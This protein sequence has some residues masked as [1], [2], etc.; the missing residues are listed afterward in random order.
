M[1]LKG[2]TEP[3]KCGSE[4]QS[5]LKSE[6]AKKEKL[7]EGLRKENEVSVCN[8]ACTYVT[9]FAKR[10]LIHAQFQV[11]LFTVIRQIQQ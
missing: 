7:I 10:D 1:K 5:T 4:E 3:S 8:Y 2:L 9:K 11:S 6:L